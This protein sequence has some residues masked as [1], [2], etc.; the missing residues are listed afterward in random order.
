MRITAAIFDLDGTVVSD[1]DEWGEAFK[2]VLQR[3]GVK[4]QSAYPHVGGIGIEEN[5]PIFIRKYNIKTNESI[6]ELSQETKKEY[7]KLIDRIR[8]KQ[9][10]LHLFRGREWEINRD[11][12]YRVWH[13]L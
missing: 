13:R 10:F 12:Q 8:L 6:E 4:E 2:I 3:L 11:R 9:G 1:E 7:V 5:W